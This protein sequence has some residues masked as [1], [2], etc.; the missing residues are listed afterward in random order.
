[1]LTASLRRAI[2]GAVDACGATGPALGLWA[3]RVA[4]E[5]GHVPGPGRDV[6][7]WWVS[8]A[9]A[10]ASASQSALFGEVVGEV[11]AG[12]AS[13]NSGA[14]R[15]VPADSGSGRAAGLGVVVGE[16][17]AASSGGRAA[18]LRAVW[19]ALAEAGAAAA[20]DPGLLGDA[21][22]ELEAGASRRA[23]GRYYT[24][25]AV[26]D[27]TLEDFALGGRVLDPACGGGRFLLAAL[28]RD[29][30]SASRLFGF[31]VDP[32]AVATCRAALFLASGPG[33][34]ASRVQCGDPLLGLAVRR[35]PETRDLFDGPGDPL[36][37]YH[38][39]HRRVD[40]LA[41]GPY[42]LVVG[43]PPYR[44]GR[45]GRLGADA[46]LFRRTFAAAEYQLDPYPLF[47]ELA[48][49]CARPGGDVALVVPN[50]WMST[51]RG[52]RLRRLLL[53]DHDLRRLVELP[54]S[55]FGAGVETVVVFVRREVG[56]RDRVPVE[57]FDDGALRPAGH[58]E[59]PSDPQAPLA[60]VRD[61]AAAALVR[62]A[63]TLRTTLGDVAE[64]TRGIN[65]YHRRMHTPEEIRARIHHADRALDAAFVPEV[66]GRDLGPYRVVW[67][68]TRFV[69]YGPWLKEPRHPRFF[70]GP[71]L[72]VR[73][74]LGPTLYA[75]YCDAPLHCDQSVYVARLREGQPW[76]VGALLACL[77]SR[78]LAALV[79]ARHQED[80]R[81]FPQI[82]V[83]ELRGLPLPD[84][85]PASPKV[86]S[87]ADA[88]LELQ[89]I[90]S[91]A[92]L[93]EGG[94]VDGPA[95][96]L[97]EALERDV[98]ALYAV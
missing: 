58:V 75:A 60:L 63:S 46:A 10:L 49:A 27:L 18:A 67:S 86:R 8:I 36:A 70:E 68:G 87:I 55:V 22:A 26:A 59:V 14:S 37:P 71:R 45:L 54:E 44:A 6:A 31:D 7:E 74:I 89:S 65:P 96:S 15:E 23:A 32:L 95:A 81:L 62:Y 90:E 4:V 79:R 11:S 3:A 56:T 42:D 19:D 85:D 78:V 91:N 43:N 38:P 34:Y 39:V 94:R 77:N 29:P 1:M 66:C 93:T 40:P 33:D 35:L 98:A 47:L 16:V 25:D 41:D 76:P 61:D 21:H 97:R 57:R 84:V 13:A 5:R 73:K 52:G 48:L 2:R 9:P 64:V 24:P 53:R 17:A 12:E 28:R 92:V 69:R 50:A 30:T 82:K 88:A 20:A 72:L 80:D 51:L 83:A